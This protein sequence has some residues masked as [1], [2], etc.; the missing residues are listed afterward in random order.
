MVKQTPT[1]K[2]KEVLSFWS[3]RV[4]GRPLAA[5][6]NNAINSF[7]KAIREDLESPLSDEDVK[8]FIPLTVAAV[9]SSPDFQWR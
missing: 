1:R 6:S 7:M 2:P 4:L 9:L 3:R 5:Q 8:W